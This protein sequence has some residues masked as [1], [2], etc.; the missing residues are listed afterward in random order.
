[1]RVAV[2]ETLSDVKQALRGAGFEVT[3]LSTGEMTDVDIAVVAGRSDDALGYQ[4]VKQDYPIIDRRGMTAEEVVDV[5]RA[6]ADQ[7]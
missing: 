5:I 4:N 1:M 7:R 6:H 3:S 2:E